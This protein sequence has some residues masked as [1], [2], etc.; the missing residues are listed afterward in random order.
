MSSRLIISDMSLIPDD[1]VSWKKHS[2]LRMA[3]RAQH[4]SYFAMHQWIYSFYTDGAYDRT[5]RAPLQ[6]P[7]EVQAGRLWP[8]LPESLESRIVKPA[9][10]LLRVFGLL[11]GMAAFFAGLGLIALAVRTELRQFM[12]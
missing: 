12:G 10:L 3:L 9:P 11:G 1:P 8:D 4:A 5:G 6:Q 2:P 7:Y